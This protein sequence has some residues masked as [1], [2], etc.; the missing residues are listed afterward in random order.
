MCVYVHVGAREFIIFG[1]HAVQYVWRDIRRLDTLCTEQPL[2]QSIL[3]YSLI[4]QSPL[5]RKDSWHQMNL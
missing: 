1:A 2:L 4:T 3:Y 5:R